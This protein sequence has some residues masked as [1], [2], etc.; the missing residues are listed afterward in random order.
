ME[1]A[2][3]I[4]HMMQSLD[5]KTTGGFFDH[6]F[7]EKCGDYYDQLTVKLGEGWGCGRETFQYLSG[8]GPLPQSSTP[9]PE[10]DFILKDEAHPY[11][12]AI[13]RKGKLLWKKPYNDYTA[14]PSRIVE[15]TT[16]LASKNYLAFLRDQGIPYL[17]CGET[18]FDPVLFL[19]K[20]RAL[21]G[22]KNFVLCGGGHINGVFM[23]AGLIDEISLVVAAVT[24]GQEK[25]LSFMEM[26]TAKAQGFALVD[27]KKLPESGLY[28][29]YRKVNE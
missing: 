3:V 24:D 10:G 16:S 19:E 26:P 11:C 8:D 13:D 1:R 27:L 20:I 9:V 29:R 21:Y 7:C 5:G 6:P 15:I 18:D 4:C 25:G 14:N 2:N 12:F 22:V 17:L 23:A 28:L